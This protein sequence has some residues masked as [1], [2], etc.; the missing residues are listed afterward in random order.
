MPDSEFYMVQLGLDAKGLTTLGKMLHL[1]LDRTDTGYLVHC[2][3]G[4]LFGDDAPQPFSID[5]DAQNGRQVRVLGYTAADA[6]TLQSHAQLDASPTV[7]EIGDWDGLAAKPM[8]QTFPDG[9]ALQFEL[10]ACPVVRKASAGE[11]VNHNGD[12]RT[13][14]EG[15]ELDAYLAEAWTRP[16][17]D[18]VSREEVYREWLR[19]QFEIRGGAE[20]QSIGMDRF[21]IE[22]MT[23][24]VPKN[25]TGER[26][27]DTLKR[28]DV[29]LTGTLRVTDGD[30]FVDLLRSGLGRHKSFGYG[31]LKVRRA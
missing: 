1:P 15:Q 19:R 28:P 8:P 25:G 29:T 7:Y 5:H 9:M 27:A 22:R 10:R 4:E 20:P 18:D 31:M 12:K 21:S 14:T 11:G 6:D 26:K 16:A 13:W 23:R 17:D 24:R 30:A 3:L 2:A